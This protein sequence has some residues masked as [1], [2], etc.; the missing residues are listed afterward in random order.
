MFLGDTSS[1][2]VVF[3]ASHSLVFGGC[4]NLLLF[5]KL[6]S[7][8]FGKRP[9]VRG[10][11]AVGFREGSCLGNFGQASE[12]FNTSRVIKSYKSIAKDESSQS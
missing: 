5:L 6:T 11:L 2:M 9:I 12:V 7:H 10:E 1:F 4:T 3:P 8:P